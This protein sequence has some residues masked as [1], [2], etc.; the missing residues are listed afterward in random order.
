MTTLKLPDELKKRIAPLAQ[1]SGKT[2]HA[3]M[4]EALEREATLAELRD[5]FIDSAL[6]SAR[7][8]DEGGP[9]YAAEDVHAWLRA[10]VADPHAPRPAP[11]ARHRRRR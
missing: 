5:G 2:P 3:W 1:R 4:I 8:I 10:R 6:A 7:E 9:L 11:I